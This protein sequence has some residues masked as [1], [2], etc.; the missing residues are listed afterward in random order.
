VLYQPDLSIIIV[1]YNG[2]Q[3]LEG[4]LAS[5][6][7]TACSLSHE[8][9]VVDNGSTDDSVHMVR[10]RFPSVHVI[11]SA[12]NLGF[13]GGNNLALASAAGRYRLLLNNDTV[14]RPGALQLLV[15]AM[16]RHP[17]LGVLG[18]RLLNVDD[19]TQLSAMH[20]PSLTRAPRNWVKARVGK[21]GKYQPRSE[22][23]VAYVDAV[24]GA[25]L[26]IRAEALYQVGLLDTGYFMY[27]E[28]MDWCY[29]AAQ[30][31][32]RIGYLA[33]AQVVHYGG[34][35]ARRE[36]E[37]FYVER[38]YSRVR[39]YAKHHGRLAAHVDDT[40]IRINLGIH[41]LLQPNERSHYR[42]LLDAYS[43]RVAPLFAH[44]TT[45]AEAGG[46]HSW[47]ASST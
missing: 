35:T 18:P 6:T 24:T 43:R 33:A 23:D 20:Y 14:V 27:A 40:F 2:A 12:E 46:G 44:G 29:R 42:A 39:F 32:W 1:N 15:Q 8:V 41:W 36:A 19:S 16:A 3:L 9:W 10:T 26:L 28:E 47:R 45:L 7:E 17:E 11:E 30:V 25:C 38:R 31:G 13:A 22:Q 4:C 34:Q 5:I 21:S 37:R